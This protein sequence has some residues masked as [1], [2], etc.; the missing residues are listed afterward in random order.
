MLDYFLFEF[1]SHYA[2]GLGQILLFCVYTLI[3]VAIIGVVFNAIVFPA[4]DWLLRTA[5]RPLKRLS[6]FFRF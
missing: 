1:P 6:D 5:S 3:I 4:S 2:K